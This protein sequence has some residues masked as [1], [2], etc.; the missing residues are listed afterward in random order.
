MA[1]EDFKAVRLKG[2]SLALATEL[3]EDFR[4]KGLRA[5]WTSV[6]DTSIPLLHAQLHGQNYT[7][8]SNAELAERRAYDVGTSVAAVLGA[9]CS[10][11]V[12]MTGCQ[13]AYYPEFDAI[14]VSLD[15]VPD[16]LIHAGGADPA[17]IANVIAKQLRSRGYL[18]DDG[19]VFV[20]M[21]QLLGASVK[22]T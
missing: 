11:K 4:L 14:C 19:T 18:K 6:V 15:A 13:L 9:L 8:V 7:M 16:T 12:D 17:A 3:I 10:A 1:K 22:G 5:T 2:R 20:D 21:D